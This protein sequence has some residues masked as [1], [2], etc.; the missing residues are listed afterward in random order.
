M[1]SIKEF[2]LYKD[3]WRIWKLEDEWRLSK[4]QHYW[5][6]LEYWE[7]SWRLEE[8]CCHS[9][10]CGKLSAGAD[11]KNSKGMNNNNYQPKILTPQIREEIY[12]SLT[13][14]GLLLDEQKGCSRGTRGAAV[15]LY[16]DKHILNESKTWRKN[17]AMAGLTSKRHMTWFHKAG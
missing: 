16:I 2:G 8:T 5:E 14:C 3:I 11:V 9:N 4:L 1:N 6:R 12:Y 13:S 7:E 10:F 15:L 17:L